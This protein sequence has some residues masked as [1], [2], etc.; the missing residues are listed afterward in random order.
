MVGCG[1]R[2]ESIVCIGN[3]IGESALLIEDTL[4]S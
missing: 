3:E 4:V 1:D 2:E